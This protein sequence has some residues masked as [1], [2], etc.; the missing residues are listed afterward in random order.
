MYKA[1]SSGLLGFPGR[2]LEDD[3][4]LAVKY[5]YEGIAFDVKKESASLSP[6]ELSA[7]LSKNGLKSGGFSLP[8]EFRK[9][10][11]TYNTDLK[12]LRGFCEFA[13]KTGTTRCTTWLMPCSDTLNYDANFL[14]HR[15]RLGRAAK[16]L[17]DHGI[18]LG[19]EFV[20][21]PSI[22][23][24]KAHEFI[25]D[26]DGLN[27]LL[28]SMGASN[29]GYLLD[30]FHW[31]LAGQA[32][33]DF[34]KIPSA[35]LVVVAHINDAPRGR[36]REEQI[37]QERELPGATGVLRLSEFFQGLRDLKYQG[38]VFVE[39]F[40]KALMA[41]DFEEAVKTAKAA[42]DKAWP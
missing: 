38:P 10:E 33:E 21:P 4:P 1:F 13:E 19:L 36:S 17:E 28:D 26:L 32:F 27:E 5:G 29:V 9:D 20:G 31:D 12:A 3:I 2:S 25:H 7:L 16:I 34:K 22:R 23:K 11:D 40:N 41:M 15:D 42:M 30:V 6:E 35:E 14:L 18:F 24:G 39:P 37:D 8:L